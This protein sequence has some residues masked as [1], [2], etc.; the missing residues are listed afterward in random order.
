MKDMYLPVIRESKTNLRSVIRFGGFWSLLR[1]AQC[2]HSKVQRLFSFV[3]EK[4]GKSAAPGEKR[5]AFLQKRSVS[6]SRPKAHHLSTK[7]AMPRFFAQTHSNSTFFLIP[8]TF[9][10]G[11]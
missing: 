6:L 10:L 8:F 2:L 7:S 9:L 3:L 11:K 1:K 4:S 5:S